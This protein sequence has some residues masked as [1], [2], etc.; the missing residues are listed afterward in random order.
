MARADGAER[1]LR[2]RGSAELRVRVHGDRLARLELP[3]TDIDRFLALRADFTELCKAL[4]FLFV[5]LDLNGF[6]S[7]SMNAVLTHAPSAIPS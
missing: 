4:G 1:W 7:G 5:S 6:R 3:L 2:E